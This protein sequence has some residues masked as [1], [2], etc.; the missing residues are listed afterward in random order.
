M[1]DIVKISGGSKLRFLTI[2]IAIVAIAIAYSGAKW[3]LGDMLARLTS[4]V[5]PNATIVADSALRLAP[6]DPYASSLRA[7]IGKDPASDDT[8]SAVE[9]A[10]ATVRLS[11]YDH[12]WHVAL[13]RALASDGQTERA[14]AEFKRATELAPS[15]ADCRWYYG[16]F[17]LRAGRGDDAVAQFKLAAAKDPEYRA[18]VLSLMWD[19]SAHDPAVLENVAGDGVDNI[20]QLARFLAGHGRGSEALTDW[21]RLNDDQKSSRSEI[22]RLIAE[23]LYEQHKFVDALEF[24]RQLGA[25]PNA[26]PETVT[27]GSFETATDSSED[28]HFNWR[29]NRADPKLDVSFDDR[30]KHDGGRS[31]RLSFKGTAKP[32]LFNAAQTVAVTPGTRYR[33]TFWLRTENLKTPVGPLID[34]STGDET[35]SLA[36]TN[37]FPNGTNEWRQFTL[38]FAVPADVDGIEIRTMRW[39]CNGDDCPISGIVWYDDFVLTRL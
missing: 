22:T 39:P 2:A 33:L 29:I 20:V 6:S 17:L 25:D 1:Q 10:E 15:Y 7:E 27:N 34:I 38:D 14:E 30:V 24:S 23:G 26:K 16:N 5:D 31:L 8:R 3:Q 28:S 37:P 35:K 36:H 21:N 9:I 12:R 32:N 4:S 13:A 18:Q 11:P 19:Y